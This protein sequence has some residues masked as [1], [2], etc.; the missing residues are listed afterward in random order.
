MTRDKA[1]KNYMDFLMEGAE[2]DVK[3]GIFT[4]ISF[5]D[6]ILFERTLKLQYSDTREL[7]EHLR[8][9]GFKLYFLRHWEEKH[10]ER[11]LK[12]FNQ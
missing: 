5:G 8:S 12:L 7:R 11:I 3:V 4:E 2:K 10:N 6:L 9:M 1:I